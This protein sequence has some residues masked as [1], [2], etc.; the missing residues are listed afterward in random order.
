M[1]PS[2]EC[3]KKHR[4]EPILLGYNLKLRFKANVSSQNVLTDGKVQAVHLLSVLHVGCTLTHGFSS[5]DIFSLLVGDQR[6]LLVTKGW[7]G[8]SAVY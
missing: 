5:I 6:L 2:Y 1:I 4:K 8:V 7:P 3:K